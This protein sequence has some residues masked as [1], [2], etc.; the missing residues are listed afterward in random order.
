MRQKFQANAS[1]RSQELPICCSMSAPTRNPRTPESTPHQYSRIV[2][3]DT[4]VNIRAQSVASWISPHQLTVSDL[5]TGEIRTGPDKTPSTVGNWIYIRN[6]EPAVRGIYK[7]VIFWSPMSTADLR[8]GEMLFL[9]RA[10][11]ARPQG[12]YCSHS[13]L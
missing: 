13:Q 10:I 9:Q 7:T 12:Y 8:E 11:R 5:W 1:T 6:A 2:V 4:L 3:G